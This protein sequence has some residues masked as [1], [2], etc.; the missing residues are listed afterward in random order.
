M[1]TQHLI[2]VYY[3]SMYIANVFFSL[4]I[5]LEIVIIGCYL[6]GSDLVPC[7]H[8]FW[9]LSRLRSVEVFFCTEASLD[10]GQILAMCATNLA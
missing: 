3:V 6:Y 5:S 2:F 8:F 10:T 1:T 7:H 4:K 9:D